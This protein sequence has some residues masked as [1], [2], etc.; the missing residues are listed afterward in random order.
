MPE[1]GV[2]GILNISKE[3]GYTSFD[4]VAVARGVYR[5]RK[6]G[7]TGTLDPMATGVLPVAFGKSTKVCGMITDW[8]KEYIAELLLGRTTDTL[9]ITGE[10]TGGD[11]SIV[12][13][14]SV[15]DIEDAVMGFAGEIEQIPPMYSALKVDGRRLYDIARSGGEVERKARKVTIHRIEI[16]DISLPVVRFKA[17]CSKGTYI[18]TLCDD[19]GRTLGCGGCMQSLIRSKVGPF[20]LDNSVRLD[21]IKKLRDE[22]N[23]EA[24]QSL[25]IPVDKV[26]EDLPSIMVNE[27][28]EKILSNGNKL[29]PEDLTE[30]VQFDDKQKVRVYHADGSF[31]A[32][33]GYEPGARI[34]RPDK[35]F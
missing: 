8:D 35:M 21:D 12:S 25:L 11:E 27:E 10:I 24:L 29:M 23:E 18:R 13:N 15:K 14:L 30:P 1:K 34:Y 5:Q 9:D 4:V 33:Y 28:S 20:D 19:I 17:L 31:A 16:L 32:V 3:A 7:H 26:F 6:C 2:N 22:G